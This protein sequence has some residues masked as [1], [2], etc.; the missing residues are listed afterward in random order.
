MGQDIIL[1]EYIA[2]SKGRDYRAEDVPERSVVESL[3]QICGSLGLSLLIAAN[4][5]GA[6]DLGGHQKPLIAL[7]RLE[8][9]GF[10]QRA[11]GVAQVGF[12]D[13]VKFSGI[14]CLDLLGQL[15]SS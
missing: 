1:Q 13:H 12:V 11:H 4:R 9:F 8:E 14:S 2:E 3:G 10:G 6:I 5:L 15:A 7:A